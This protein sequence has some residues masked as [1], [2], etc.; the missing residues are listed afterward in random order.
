MSNGE[1]EE[2]EAHRKSVKI[3]LDDLAAYKSDLH[4]QCDFVLANFDI[5]QKARTQEIEA[6]QQAQSFLSG[7]QD[8]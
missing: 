1:K 3:T 7:M 2:Q 4:E 5:R 8:D 6:I